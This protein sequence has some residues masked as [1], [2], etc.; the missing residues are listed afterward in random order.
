[1]SEATVEQNL[2]TVRCPIKRRGRHD[3]K[4]YICN[5]TIIKVLPGSAGQAYCRDC[6]KEFWFEVDSQARNTTGVRVKPLD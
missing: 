6:Q 5:R 2:V 4:I 1:M 3:T